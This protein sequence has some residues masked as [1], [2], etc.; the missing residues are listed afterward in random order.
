MA[1][2]RQRRQNVLLACLLVSIGTLHTTYTYYRRAVAA[3]RRLLRRQWK[4]WRQCQW[5]PRNRRS[6][7]SHR[8]RSR[9]R[10]TPAAPSSAS[11][12]APPLRLRSSSAS[13]AA[14]AVVV[15]GGS[16]NSVM[17]FHK[18]RQIYYNKN[19]KKGHKNKK[20]LKKL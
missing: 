16:A 5:P 19:L 11:T 18:F 9:R 14:A 13:D 1:P 12:I 7:H 15:G 8:R 6:R 3:V 20:K 2:N 4:L 10:R 17:S